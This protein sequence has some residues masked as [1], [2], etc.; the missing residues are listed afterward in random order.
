MPRGKNCRE[1]IF[2]SQL[3]RNC[4]HRGGNFAS[5]KNVLYCGERQFGRHFKR[6]FGRRVN[7]S[8]K[9]PRDS[10]ESI[11]AARQQDVSQGPLGRPTMSQLLYVN[12]GRDRDFRGFG[13]QGSVGGEIS[14]LVDIDGRRT[15]QA[16]ANLDPRV[17]PRVAPRVGPRVAPRVLPLR[18]PTRA[19]FPVFSPSRTLHETSHEGVHGRAHEWTVGVHLSCFHL[20]CSLT[21]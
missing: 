9:L 11:F 8:Q 19:D 15:E 21:N 16:K 17:G 12:G 5:G 6:Q 7:A 14:V 18:A 20:F 13:A 2:V 1:T 4:P 10:G 3:P